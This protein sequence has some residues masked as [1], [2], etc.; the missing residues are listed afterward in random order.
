MPRAQAWE[1]YKECA[2]ASD[3]D[4]ALRVVVYHAVLAVTLQ[5][6]GG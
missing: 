2:A 4:C 5:N 6:L 3:I 1:M